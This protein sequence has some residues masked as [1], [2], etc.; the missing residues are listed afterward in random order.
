MW[1]IVPAVKHRIPT[2]ACKIYKVYQN[3]QCTLYA[4]PSFYFCVSW[5]YLV[6]IESFYSGAAFKMQLKSLFSAALFAR[7]L[8]AAPA[9]GQTVLRF[10]CSQI[11]VERLDP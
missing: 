8:F 2:F 1:D 6:H 9:A 5:I 11:V 7:G 3:G 4:I 10:G